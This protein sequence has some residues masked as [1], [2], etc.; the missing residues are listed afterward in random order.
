MSNVYMGGWVTYLQLVEH[1]HRQTVSHTVYI[2]VASI[3]RVDYYDYENEYDYY[4]YLL[5]LLLLHYH[6]YYYHH[7]YYY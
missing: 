4:F 2:Q 5:R 1:V 6:H 3:H 7:Y